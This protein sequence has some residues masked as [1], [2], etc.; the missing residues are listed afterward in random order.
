MAM[1]IIIMVDSIL[2]DKAFKLKGRLYTLTVL[3]LASTDT[4]VVM[5]QL[6]ELTS[7]APLMF[8]NTPIILDLNNLKVDFARFDALITCLKTHNLIPV[9]VQSSEPK[10]ASY[11][12][13]KGFAL[14]H[15]SSNQDKQYEETA[16]EP[17]KTANKMLTSPVRSGQQAVCK[18]GDL[19][20]ASSV[21]H[22]AELLADGNIHVYG[23]LRGRALAGISGDVSA[24]IF[25]QSLDA[26][27]VSIAGHYK[28]SDAMEPVDKPCQIFLKDGLICIEALC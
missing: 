23:A 9:G 28:L 21:S 5:A 24:R 13:E 11:A 20:V 10:L 1:D 2:K 8:S 14:L 18:G 16:A 7:K 15:S 25:C 12:K 27:L 3:Q 26:E 17:V 19:I 22:G 6:V 4:D